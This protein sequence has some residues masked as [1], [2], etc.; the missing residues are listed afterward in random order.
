[1]YKFAYAILCF[2]L[3]SN[4]FASYI[5]GK[6]ELHKEQHFL[7]FCDESAEDVETVVL[8]GK[9]IASGVDF[10]QVLKIE[11]KNS[12]FLGV[13][14]KSYFKD[15]PG[16]QFPSK[17]LLQRV[18]AKLADGHVVVNAD[19]NAKYDT[20][21]RIV[22]RGRVISVFDDVAIYLKRG[23]FKYVP[24]AKESACCIIKDGCCESGFKV[25]VSKG[26]AARLAT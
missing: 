24:A 4:I 6:Q 12:E 21:E 7:V 22:D 2:L 15:I 3:T 26:F 19:V 1:M 18:V 17:I 8:S 14:A 9:I 23:E 16:M 20:D 5:G 10:S 25:L 13:D 11:K